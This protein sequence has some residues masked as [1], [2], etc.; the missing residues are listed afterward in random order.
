MTNRPPARPDPAL[1]HLTETLAGELEPFDVRV[2]GI[3]AV[4]AGEHVAVDRDCDDLSRRMIGR[5]PFG[6]GQTPTLPDAVAFCAS[7]LSM[8]MS[9]STLLATI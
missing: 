2:F 9:G 3:H 6:A 5:L 1:G 8:F 4:R 7:D